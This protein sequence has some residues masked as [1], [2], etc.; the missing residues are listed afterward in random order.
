MSRATG[1]VLLEDGTRLDGELCGAGGH[2]VG[3][4]VFTTGMAGYQESMTDPSFAGQLIAFTYP[5]IGNYGAS[6]QA[7]ESERPWARAA[8][9]RE[10]CNREDAPTCERGWLDWL[11]D[12]GVRA[13]S[14]VDTRTLVKHIRSEGAM[15][16]G[17]FDAGTSEAHAR[18]LIDAEPPMAGQDLARVVTPPSVTRHGSG[19]GPAI[20]VIDTGIKA[21]MV[22][23]LVS[24][25]A[26]VSLHPCTA[27]VEELL[28]EDPDAVFLANG[29]GDPAALGYVVETVRQIVGRKPVWGICLGHQLLC[30]AVGLETFKLPFGHR[31]ANHPVRD[32]HTGR[33][34]ITSQNHGFAAVGPDGARTIDGQEP[35]RWETDFGAAALSHVNLYDRTVEG[36]ELLDVPGGTVQYHPE[37]GPGPHDSLYLFDR[38]L[39][40]IAQSA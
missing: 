5:H 36:L 24:R 25:G 19:D 6:A 39:G 28:A 11:S 40:R 14:G 37:A 31:G 27:G 22:R 34:E 29:P 20:A 9:M 32:L 8:I 15:R 3:E 16:G 7:M 17:V 38:F 35:V 30:R 13:I 26:R 4:V 12:C 10:A 2:A 21:S 33:V 1:Y 18:E 23:E